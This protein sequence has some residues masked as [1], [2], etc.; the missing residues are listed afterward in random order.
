MVA[1]EFGAILASRYIH[2]LLAAII[3]WAASHGYLLHAR[4][5]EKSYFGC[6]PALS[7]SN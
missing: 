6:E 3:T 2:A 1:S 5:L 4:G 7:D